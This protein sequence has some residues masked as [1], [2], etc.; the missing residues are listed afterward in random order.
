MS[1][2]IVLL[3]LQHICQECLPLIGGRLGVCS[4]SLIVS[5]RFYLFNLLRIQ[6]YLACLAINSFAAVSFCNKAVYRIREWKQ[7]A[8]EIHPCLRTCSKLLETLHL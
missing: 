8:Y 4:S 3:E 6:N 7:W 5:V 1:G 2:H